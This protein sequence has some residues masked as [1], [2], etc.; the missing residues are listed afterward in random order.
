[1]SKNIEMNYKTDSG[2]EVLY[3]QTITNNISDFSSSVSSLLGNYYTKQQIDDINSQYV[4]T[5][6]ISNSNLSMSINSRNDYI[7]ISNI[8]MNAHIIIWLGVARTSQVPENIGGF[9]FINYSVACI[10]MRDSVSFVDVI[11]GDGEV[12]IP[13]PDIGRFYLSGYKAIQIF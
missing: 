13:Y 7:I 3:P 9:V 2:Y 6:E 8:N 1:M 12:N 5:G 4:K 10:G 11:W